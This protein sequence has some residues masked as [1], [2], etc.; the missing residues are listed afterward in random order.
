M[1]T[2]LPRENQELFDPLNRESNK[3]ETDQSIVFENAFRDVFRGF[4]QFVRYSSFPRIT[5]NPLAVY[6][7]VEL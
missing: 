1:V 4:E 7:E 3:T 6:R 5:V 2:S